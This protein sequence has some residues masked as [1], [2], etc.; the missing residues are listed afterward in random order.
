MN[1]TSK[2]PYYEHL[3]KKWI[4]KHRSLANKLFE[5][6]KEV[7]RQLAVGGLG[8]LMLLTT[9]GTGIMPHQNILVAGG[10][11]QKDTDNN[12]LLAKDL[13]DKIPKEMRALTKEE[14]LEISGIVSKNTGFNVSA[15]LEGKRLNRSYGV[16]GGEQH[17][18]RFPGDNLHKHADNAADWA[19]YGSSGIAPGLGAWGYFAPSE[20]QFDDK[21]KMQERYYLAVQTFLAPGFAE[22]VAEYRDFF[23]F[24]KMLVVNPQT[25]QSVVAV[26]GDAGPAEWTGKHLG[27]SPEVMH[28]LGLSKG[29]RKGPVLY[30]FMDDPEDKIPLGPVKVEENLA[31]I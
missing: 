31:Q 16:I 17:L 25:G 24:R 11:I 14:E 12:I 29:S 5:K 4:A 3:R 27:G 30:F 9:P 20:V 21:A 18:Y 15:E 1:F 13:E 8:G 22:R 7:G 6:H 23:K 28:F 10:Q 19:M 26:I 2:K